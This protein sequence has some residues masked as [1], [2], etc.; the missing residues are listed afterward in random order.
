MRKGSDSGSQLVLVTGAPRTATTP[1]AHVLSW[2]KGTHVLY[3][4]MG[5][6]GDRRVP[7]RFAVPGQ[8]GFSADRRHHTLSP[9][10]I[11]VCAR[12]SGR[13]QWQL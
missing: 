12:L 5:P 4:P 7:S 8:P 2:A 11:Q 3:E 9:D 13:T 6:T 10:C 1:F